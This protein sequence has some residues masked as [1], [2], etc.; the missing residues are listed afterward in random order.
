MEKEIVL[1]KK[2]KKESRWKEGNFL[3][4]SFA[5]EKRKILTKVSFYLFSDT[6]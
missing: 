4:K 6:D 3:F 2:W 1:I 5:K